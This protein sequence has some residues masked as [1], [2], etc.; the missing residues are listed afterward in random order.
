MTDVRK[1]S[2]AQGTY[3]VYSEPVDR[4]VAVHNVV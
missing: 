2:P 4:E 1:M 3:C